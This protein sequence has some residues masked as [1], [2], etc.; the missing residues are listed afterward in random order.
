MPGGMPEGLPRGVLKVR[1]HRYIEVF[2]QIIFSSR[3]PCILQL[4]S[5]R[6]VISQLFDTS[7]EAVLNKCTVPV[8]FGYVC[9]VPN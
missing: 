5:L 7:Y 9:L 6:Q 8:K 2:Y 4:Q 3:F 1:F